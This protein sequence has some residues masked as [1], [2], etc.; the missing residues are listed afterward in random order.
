MEVNAYANPPLISTSGMQQ[1]GTTSSPA[2]GFNADLEQAQN[3]TSTPL[4]SA[5]TYAYANLS[6]EDSLPQEDLARASDA[7]LSRQIRGRSGMLSMGSFQSGMPIEPNQMYGS[8][9]HSRAYYRDQIATMLLLPSAERV[10]VWESLLNGCHALA[11]VQYENAWRNENLADEFP[12]EHQERAKL[13]MD[14]A[15][16]R[17]DADRQRRLE[18]CSSPDETNSSQA[19]DDPMG[20]IVDAIN[21]R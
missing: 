9:Q 6:T 21:R 4:D 1:G 19:S 2:A 18:E 11:F 16:T 7:A 20:A 13:A 8:N 15:R 5:S 12:A 14:A 3:I 17:C 10:E